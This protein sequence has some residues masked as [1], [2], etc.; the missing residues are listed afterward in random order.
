MNLN[1][2]KHEPFLQNRY[3]LTTTAS[4][5]QTE[6]SAKHGWRPNLQVTREP[7]CS[8]WPISDLWSVP[9]LSRTTIDLKVV[10]L[11]VNPLLHTTTRFVFL[12][13]Y[14]LLLIHSTAGRPAS[15][16]SLKLLFIC[17]L[18]SVDFS[19]K[20]QIIKL[21]IMRAC[22]R[23]EPNRVKSSRV[24]LTF[25]FILSYKLGQARLRLR[26]VP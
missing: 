4:R 20:N 2:N 10:D 17:E 3:R 13:F 6:W 26:L 19:D 22:S 16:K 9:T 18:V 14:L 7:T 5:R 23:A 24:E 1:W 21:T 25:C 8:V 15:L 12:R 11:V